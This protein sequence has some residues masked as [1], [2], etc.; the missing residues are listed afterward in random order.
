MMLEI[1]SSTIFIWL[2]NIFAIW[3]WNKNIFSGEH[4]NLC[5]SVGVG[6]E[7]IFIVKIFHNAK[8]MF[9][10][11]LV[12][13]FFR[14]LLADGLNE[15][16]PFYTSILARPAQAQPNPTPNP[17]VRIVCKL[18]EFTLLQ[19]YLNILYSKMGLGTFWKV[20]CYSFEMWSRSIATPVVVVDGWVAVAAPPAVCVSYWCREQ[21]R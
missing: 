11:M 14:N 2:I 5:G 8:F 1:F 4:F 15:T 18:T 9:V 19:R 16:F 10:F 21:R 6:G 12:W 13:A 3:I 17:P 7:W 20:K